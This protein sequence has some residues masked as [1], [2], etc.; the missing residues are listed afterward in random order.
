V[1]RKR[2]NGAE[3]FG[4]KFRPVVGERPHQTE[5]GFTIFAQGSFG[6]VKVALQCNSGAVVEGVG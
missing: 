3:D 5:P 6:I 2:I 1:P 4:S